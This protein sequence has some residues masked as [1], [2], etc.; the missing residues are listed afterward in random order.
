MTL[1]HWIMV[2]IAVTFFSGHAAASGGGGGGS[3]S[4]AP[5]D[6]APAYD[7]TVEFAKGNA[8]LKAGDYKAADRAFRN[9]L[10]VMPRDAVTLYLSGLTK[11]GLGDDKGAAKAYEKSLK[12]DDKSV[13]AHRDYALTLIKL[14]EKAKASAELATLNTMATACAE[15][16]PQATDLKAAVTAVEASAAPTADAAPVMPLFASSLMFADP[17]AGARDGDSAYLQAVQLINEQRYSAALEALQRAQASFG[18]HPDVLTYIGYTYRK[19]HRYADAERYYRAALHI[20]PTHRGATE[21]YG[22]LMAERGDI[23]GARVM[24]ARLDAQCSFGC[25]EAEDLRRWILSRAG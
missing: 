1:H 2:G 16:C 23:A 8:A 3:F 12:Y 21:Y 18:P 20:A 14:G 24:L 15:T 5:S 22:E 7:P 17:G 6:S 13:N 9:V 11:A 10:S 19:M 4:G 25:I